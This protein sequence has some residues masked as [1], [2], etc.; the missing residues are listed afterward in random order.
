MTRDF[1]DPTRRID[2]P[3]ER[4]ITGICKGSTRTQFNQDDGGYL[5]ALDPGSNRQAVN[6]LP[7]LGVS[8]EHA[9][10]PGD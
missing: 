7:S 5:R 10:V 6:K 8:T 9:Q 3:D 1:F 2:S 4:R